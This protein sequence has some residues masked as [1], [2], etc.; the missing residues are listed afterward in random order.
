MRATVVSSQHQRRLFVFRLQVLSL[1]TPSLSV[2]RP[3]ENWMMY[4]FSFLKSRKVIVWDNNERKALE[5]WK[6]VL[7][8]KWSDVNWRN[9]HLTV[10]QMRGVWD[11]TTNGFYTIECFDDE[12]VVFESFSALR[13]SCLLK[14][15]NNKVNLRK[16]NNQFGYYFS[17]KRVSWFKVLGLRQDLVGIIYY[18]ASQLHW[19]ECA[20]VLSLRE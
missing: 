14:Y 11:R 7:S 16:L 20:Y 3:I 1:C 15:W 8:I 18:I 4:L 2:L 12:I 10:S 9:L 5:V 19:S 6:F 17:Q 13:T